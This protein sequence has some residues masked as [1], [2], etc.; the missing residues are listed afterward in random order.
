MRRRS[1]PAP[2][3]R[4]NTRRQSRRRRR[5]LRQRRRAHAEDDPEVDDLGV[6]Q[7]AAEALHDQLVVIP[8]VLESGD[9]LGIAGQR[10]EN[11]QFELGIVGVDEHA[12]LGSTEETAEF[13]VGRDVLQIRS[14]L[15]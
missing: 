10:R 5:L 15:V 14:V 2:P 9:H 4:A 6:P 11:P 13:R 8:T 12:A 3:S 7:D 1:E